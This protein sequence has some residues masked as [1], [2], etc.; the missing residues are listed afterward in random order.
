MLVGDG[1]DAA[2]VFVAETAF[3]IWAVKASDNR[4]LKLKLPGVT[5]QEPASRLYGTVIKKSWQQSHW[6][7]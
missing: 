1:V 5:D 2:V 6:C 7:E 4:Q 3:P